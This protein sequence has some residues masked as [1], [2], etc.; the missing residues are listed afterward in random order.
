ME[1]LT[2]EGILDNA[3]CRDEA[4]AIRQC[5]PVAEL[6]WVLHTVQPE[7]R[8]AIGI[9]EAWMAGEE[10]GVGVDRRVR[11]RNGPV[12]HLAA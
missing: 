4:M 3:G 6:L 7:R 2:L 8:T 1:P 11:P 12:D 9:L 5:R 10:L